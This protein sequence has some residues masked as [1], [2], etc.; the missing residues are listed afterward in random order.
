VALDVAA[1]LEPPPV[2]GL[3]WI[4]GP[5]RGAPLTTIKA[6]RR[7]AIAGNMVAECPR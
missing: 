7:N 2:A 6:A 5:C 4:K 3:T 1:L